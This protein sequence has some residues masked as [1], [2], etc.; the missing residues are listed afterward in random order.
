MRIP[1]STLD[2]EEA[3]WKQGILHTQSMVPDIYNPSTTY[4]YMRH[5]HV[6][7]YR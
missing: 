7:V 4:M 3:L 1:K 2:L 5:C 6:H